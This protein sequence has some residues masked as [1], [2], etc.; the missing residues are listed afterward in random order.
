M[1]W[2]MLLVVICGVVA[3]IYKMVTKEEPEL[4][5]LIEA[6]K[7]AKEDLVATIAAKPDEVK[8]EEA[9]APVV[10]AP[11]PV[12]ET[13]EAVE[14][15]VAQKP[16]RKY[17]KKTVEEIKELDSKAKIVEEKIAAAVAKR[18]KAK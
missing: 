8:V 9:S 14:T 3:L 13:V 1:E 10:E 6:E 12:V 7:K 2:L 17:T 16:K 15:P 18:K 11:A 5:A 4:D